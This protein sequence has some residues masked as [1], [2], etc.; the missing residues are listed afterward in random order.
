M[1]AA[2]EPICRVQPLTGHTSPDTAY[3]LDDYPYGRT[4]RCAIRCWVETGATDR[5]RGQQR[6]T[7]QTANPKHAA[8]V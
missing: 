3:V 1:S 5:T 8:T 4:L 7:S 6:L 2:I